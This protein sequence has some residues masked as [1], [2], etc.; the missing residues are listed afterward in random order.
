[1]L[2]GLSFEKLRLELYLREAKTHWPFPL[3][4]HVSKV[5]GGT[6]FPR[7]KKLDTEI[8]EE[9]KSFSFCTDYMP[10][11]SL[12]QSLIATQTWLGLPRVKLLSFV[13][14]FLCVQPPRHYCSFIGTFQKECDVT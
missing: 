9:K 2:E 14:L 1:M 8:S 4:V 12:H 11:G 6:C 7:E 5:G 13:D 3:S 10:C